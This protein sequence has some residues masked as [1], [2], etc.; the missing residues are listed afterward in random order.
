MGRSRVIP[1]FPK[2][3][4]VPVCNNVIGITNAHGTLCSGPDGDSQLQAARA[5]HRRAT[6]E[7]AFQQVLVI[8]Y[9]VDKQLRANDGAPDRKG[10]SRARTQNDARIDMRVRVEVEESPPIARVRIVPV[11][12]TTSIDPCGGQ[13]ESATRID[14]VRRPGHALVMVEIEV[15]RRGIGREE[16]AGDRVVSVGVVDREVHIS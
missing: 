6:E 11:G 7:R 5:A 12:K 10:V 1:R 3:A 9:V 13:I 8:E 4:S 15:P 16:T 2:E 14:H